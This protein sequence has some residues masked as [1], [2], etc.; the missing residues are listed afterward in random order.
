ME[1]RF[2]FRAWFKGR[3]EY[4]IA[5]EAKMLYNIEK[6][7]DGANFSSK[8]DIDE[9]L[10]H[11]QCFGE[12]LYGR[13]DEGNNDEYI[14]MQ[15]TGLKDKNGKLIY[16]GDLIEIIYGD[17][18]NGFSSYGGKPEYTHV[19]GRVVYIFDSWKVKHTHP[20]DK[21]IVYVGLNWLIKNNSKEIVG[22]IYENS[23][24]IN[25]ETK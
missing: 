24:L 8:D 18:P 19:L 6:L 12:M 7:Y 22:N 2:K 13:C 16:E 9:S 17:T 1:D 4:S 10:G 14:V 15:C 11:V 20:N 25:K 5:E 3:D 23:E 21:E